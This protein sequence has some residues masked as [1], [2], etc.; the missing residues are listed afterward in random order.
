MTAYHAL[1]HPAEERWV[2]C[3]WGNEF[4]VRFTNLSQQQKI[5]SLYLDGT[6][7]SYLSVFPQQTVTVM[8]VKVGTIVEEKGG[9]ACPVY[10]PLVFAQPTLSGDDSDDERPLR[11]QM[12]GGGIDE[13]GRVTLDVYD[14]IPT[15]P[16]QVAGFSVQGAALGG[17]ASASKSDGKKKGKWGGPWNIAEKHSLFLLGK[18]KVKGAALDCH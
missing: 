2:K 1:S 14:A 11:A 10:K 8:E 12:A 16:V 18:R 7:I 3:D 6:R 9:G 15:L 17:G 4:G 13:L 5:C